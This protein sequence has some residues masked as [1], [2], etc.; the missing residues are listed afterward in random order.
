MYKISR[1][2]FDKW[3]TTILAQGFRVLAPTVKDFAI[4][5]DEIDN[6][7]KLPIGISDIQLPGRYN[8]ITRKDKAYF[9]YNTPMDSFKK[10]LF[11]PKRKLWQAKR[12]GND[13]AIKEENIKT[14]KQIF[15]GVRSCDLKA[16]TVQDKIFLQGNFIDP[17][18]K[19]QRDNTII[20]AVNC[21]TASE[22]CFCVSMKSGPNVVSD[23]DILLTEIINENQHDFII[24]IGSKKGKQ[25]IKNLE[26]IKCDKEDLIKEN[27][28]ITKA[29]IK[30]NHNIKVDTA[31]IKELFYKSLNHN[32]WE[33]IAKRCLSCANCTLVCPTCFCSNIEEVSD[34]TGNHTERWQIWD[35]CFNADH[36]YIHN[37]EIRNSVKSRYRQWL[38]HKMASWID[39]FGVSGCVGC[40]RC[41]SWCPV[42]IDLREEIAKLNNTEKI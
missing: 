10:W 34:I 32:L 21:T 35:S 29:I 16:I 42:G 15:L 28:E 1:S 9:A 22:N 30:I 3:F 40:G 41:I 33:D 24:K 27:N 23:F 8:L 19:A 17:Y 37:G 6:I 4:K 5:L 38:T 25:L 31:N 20:V 14:T 36:S 26:V 39:Q 18:Y 11:P 2:E 7:N 13:V 12:I